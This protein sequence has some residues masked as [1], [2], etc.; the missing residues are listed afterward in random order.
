[1]TAGAFALALVATFLP[2]S[3]FG[4][5]AGAFGAWDQGPR[6]SSLAATAAVLGCLAWAARRLLLP[7]RRWLDVAIAVLGGLVSVG[8][9]MSIWH[10]PAFTRTWIGPWIALLAG[11]VACAS[12]VAA[13]RTPRGPFDAPI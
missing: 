11:V 3:R 4:V 9:V 6:W 2:W 7:S 13:R 12:A 1:V 10:R 8:A 5:G